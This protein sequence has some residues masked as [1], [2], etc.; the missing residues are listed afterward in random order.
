MWHRQRM[1]LVTASG[2]T[3]MA[4]VSR[5]SITSARLNRRPSSTKTSCRAVTA[6]HEL[7]IAPLDEAMANSCICPD[8][9]HGDGSQAFDY[10]ANPFDGPIDFFPAD[11]KWRRD[12]DH[13]I[14]GFLA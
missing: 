12:P 5:S 14:V 13:M 2:R 4:G 3:S 8:T 1:A 10:S 9:R 7:N 6:R 11:G